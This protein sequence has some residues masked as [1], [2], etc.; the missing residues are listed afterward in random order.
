M[1]LRHIAEATSR[2]LAGEKEPARLAAVVIEWRHVCGAQ[3]ENGEH[4]EF[5]F[6]VQE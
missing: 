2:R 1:E 3:D 4:V 6:H 5:G